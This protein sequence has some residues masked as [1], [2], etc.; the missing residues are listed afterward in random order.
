MKKVMGVIVAALLSVGFMGVPAQATLVTLALP[1]NC[2][3]CFGSDYTLIISQDVNSSMV[4][5]KLIID[6]TQYTG[7]GSYI[8]AVDFK[9]ANDFTNLSLT[10]A[11]G[12]TSSWVTS[13]NGI[14]SSGCDSNGKGFVCSQD[15]AVVL[16]APVGVG[17]VYEWDWQF[18]LPAGVTLN[19]ADVHIGAKYNN[20]QGTLNGQITSESVPVPE[21]AT[22]LLLGSGLVGLGA[23]AWR[24][25]KS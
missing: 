13:S 22:L 16:A 24:R 1:D 7:K 14:N 17:K 21:P 15:P 5:A 23:F 10:K 25:R 11:P 3:S 20:A 9:V 6:T 12:D 18:T 4:T 2:P 19:L 8:S